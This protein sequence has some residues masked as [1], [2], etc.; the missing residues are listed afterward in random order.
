MAALLCASAGGT[1]A[2]VMPP[3][4][5]FGSGI[6]RGGVFLVLL[7]MVELDCFDL[8]I[9]ACTCWGRALAMPPTNG[10]RGGIEWR[11]FV[12]LALGAGSLALS[13]FLACSGA[14]RL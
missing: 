7:F 14:L 1:W 9:G 10:F 12:A 3:A 4:E 6:E 11:C 2:L 8:L 5:G 13:R